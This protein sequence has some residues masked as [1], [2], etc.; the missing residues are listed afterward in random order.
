[1]KHYELNYLISPDLSEEELK[2][3]QE[4]INSNIQNEGGKLER[5]KVPIRKKLA[6]PIKKKGAAYLVTSD[7][8]FLPEK[9]ENFEKKLK[10]ES[11]ILRY[12]ILTK[13]MLK[14]TEIPQIV[15]E[16]KVPKVKKEKK[17]ELEKIGEKLEE[18][19]GEI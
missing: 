5:V 11:N 4:K 17:V 2:I 9:L 8:Y 16:A 7:F 6:Y 13:E 12:L 18:I 1:M 10:A 14:K 19:L 3:F 15:P